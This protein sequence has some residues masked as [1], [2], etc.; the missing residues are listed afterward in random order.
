MSD[1]IVPLIVALAFVG[2]GWLI[3]HAEPQYTDAIRHTLSVFA[4]VFGLLFVAGITAKLHALLG[5][6]RMTHRVEA[7]SQVDPPAP[8]RSARA[9]G[10]R[11]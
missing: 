9:P 11:P 5:V 4:L 10:A 7:R 3:V 6:G 8:A 2:V 1:L